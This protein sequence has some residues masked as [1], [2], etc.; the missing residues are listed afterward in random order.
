VRFA[1]PDNPDAGLVF[2]GRIAED[3]KLMNG[4][5]V[6]VGK[7]RVGALAAATPVL[8]DA[9]VCGEGRE[10][11]GL[12]AWLNAA[13]CKQ[14]TGEEGDLAFYAAHPKVHAHLRKAF[15]E[16]NKV[17]TGAT[18]RVAR[19]LLL[20]DMP[21]IDA[22]EIT[23]KGYINQRVALDNRRA[24]VERLYDTNPQPDVVLIG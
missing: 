18:M 21:S 19:V 4:T 1:D 5:W 9:I 8:Q 10:Q 20:P 11:V 15:G 14:V 23:D 13:G 24:A 12:V 17:N 7:L 3:F 16:W 6:T 2:D 22:N